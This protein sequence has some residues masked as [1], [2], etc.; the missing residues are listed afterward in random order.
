MGFGWLKAGEKG[1]EMRSGHENLSSENMKQMEEEEEE[2]LTLRRN[3]FGFRYVK[4]S[5]IDET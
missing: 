4:M 3:L 1:E 5:A 2:V